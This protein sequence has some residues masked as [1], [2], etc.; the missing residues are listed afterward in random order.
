MSNEI[1]AKKIQRNVAQIDRLEI[2]AKMKEVL[3]N[4]NIKVVLPKKSGD[5][6]KNRFNVYITD[7]IEITGEQRICNIEIEDTYIEI[8]EYKGARGD[9]YSGFYKMLLQFLKK[10]NIQY[11]KKDNKLIFGIHQINEILKILEEINNTYIEGKCVLKDTK[12]T[13]IK[14]MGENEY[15]CPVKYYEVED[16]MVTVEEKNMDMFWEDMK[17]R[18]DDKCKLLVEGTGN[19][20]VEIYAHFKEMRD[21]IENIMAEC[22]GRKKLLEKMRG[23]QL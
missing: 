19:Q 11:K 1:K 6:K 8:M 14:K 16:N 4:A 20:F 21:Y 3:K 13:F 23:I 18:M 17:Y 10:E 5:R 2:P 22:E 15:K 12:I 7:A 9:R